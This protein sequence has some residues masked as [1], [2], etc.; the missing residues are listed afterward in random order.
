VLVGTFDAAGAVTYIVDAAKANKEQQRKWGGQVNLVNRPR[1]RD[2][3]L[4]SPS[5][6]PASF[7]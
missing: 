5:S 3:E 4:L 1:P 2:K 7:I 6:S